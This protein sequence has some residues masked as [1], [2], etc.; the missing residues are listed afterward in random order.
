[1]WKFVNESTQDPK[2][3]TEHADGSIHKFHTRFVDYLID[4]LP[5]EKLDLL[6]VCVFNFVY[7]FISITLF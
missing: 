4:V 2:I 1:M 3:S 6:N 5:Q 7:I